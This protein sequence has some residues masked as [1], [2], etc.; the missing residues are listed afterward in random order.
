MYLHNGLSSF[1]VSKGALKLFNTLNLLY[2][3]LVLSTRGNS[4]LDISVFLV[5][6]RPTEKKKEMIKKGSIASFLCLMGNCELWEHHFIQRNC[7]GPQKEMI[8]KTNSSLGTYHLRWSKMSSPPLF[9]ET[10]ML[11]L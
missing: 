7:R 8:Y 2:S 11:V 10:L 9:S 1:K 6:S 4:S 3:S 5:L